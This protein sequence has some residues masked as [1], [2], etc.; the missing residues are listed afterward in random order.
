[1]KLTIPTHLMIVGALV[2]SCSGTLNV[3]ASPASSS[4]VVN[5]DNADTRISPPG[6]AQIKILA[7]GQ[8]AFLGQLTLAPG[9]TVPEHSDATEEYIHIL[10]GSGDIVIDGQSHHVTAGT[11]IFMPAGATVSFQN[12]D[13]EMTALQ[14]F[15]NPQPADKYNAW[16]S[17]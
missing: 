8:E 7:R 6:T 16:L 5:L 10:S 2:F 11:T 12:G 17:P 13:Q 14:V 15:A 1:M 9:A 3:L 4:T